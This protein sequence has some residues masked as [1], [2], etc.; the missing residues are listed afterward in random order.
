MN[1]IAVEKTLSANDTSDT[2]GHQAG[3]LIP[4]TGGALDFFPKLDSSIKN[5]RVAL[6]FVDD[7]GTEWTFQFIYYNTRILGI[8]TRNEYRLTGMTAFLRHFSLKPGD[9]VILKRLSDRELRISYKRGGVSITP[10]GKLQLGRSGWRLV[11][12][13]E[14]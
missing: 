11:E 6:D 1:P 5:P 14:D 7:G 8:G 13:D 2:G 3:M 12:C 4:K 9:K 10:Q